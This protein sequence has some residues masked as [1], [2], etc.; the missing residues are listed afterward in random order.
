MTN[1]QRLKITDMRNQGCGYTAI[2]NAVGL[3]KDSVKAFCRSH[4][5]AG[6]KAEPMISENSVT[7]ICLNC[8]SPLTHNPGAKRKKFCGSSCRQAWWNTHPDRV[9]RKALYQFTCP[10]CGK[11]FTAYGNNHRKYC[12]RSCYITARFKGGGTA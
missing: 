12:S 7:D 6:V 9:T 8:G 10:A 4:G 5:L 3:T 2:A 1:E 11:P